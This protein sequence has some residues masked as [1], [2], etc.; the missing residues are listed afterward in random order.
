LAGDEKKAVKRTAF[1]LQ[2]NPASPGMQLHVA[3]KLND[4]D[5]Q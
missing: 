5:C 4:E 1:D 3:E 2:R